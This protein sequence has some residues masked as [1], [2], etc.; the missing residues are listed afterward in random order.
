MAV[1]IVVGFK[2]VDVQQQNGEGFVAAHGLLPA[3]FSTILKYPAIKQFCQAIAFGEIAKFF[4]DVT[5][6]VRMAIIRSIARIFACK[7]T[8]RTG[9]IK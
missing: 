2:M 1:T 9:F 8:R 6:L 3:L 7:I 5:Q 4:I